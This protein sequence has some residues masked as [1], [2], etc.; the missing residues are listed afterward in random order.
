MMTRDEILLLPFFVHKGIPFPIPIWY[1]SWLVAL[2]H[3]LQCPCPCPSLG[4]QPPWMSMEIRRISWSNNIMEL[5]L[6]LNCSFLEFIIFTGTFS[7]WMGGQ[8]NNKPL[9]SGVSRDGGCGRMRCV[10]V[11]DWWWL[12]DCYATD[13]R[14]NAVS[15]DLRGWGEEG[16]MERRFTAHWHGGS[17]SFWQDERALPQS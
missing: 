13:H 9:N 5:L 8:R 16:R 12:N 1:S 3:R 4:N 15:M 10:V 2:L 14:T 17:K 7:G 11:D 6:Q